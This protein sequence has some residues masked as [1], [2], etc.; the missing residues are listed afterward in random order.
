MIRPQ[1]RPASTASPLPQRAPLHQQ[2]RARALTPVQL[3]LQHHPPRRPAR[4]RLV[5]VQVRHQ[6][7]G[8]QQLLDPLPL[9]RRDRQQRHVPAVLLDLHPVLRQPR[10]HPLRI[11]VLE[12][13]LVQRD[14]HR[15]PRRAD[16]I[17]R[18]AGLRHHPVVG[19]DDQHRDVRRVG[20]PRPHP[21]E[22]LVPRRVD[23]RQQ[24]IA[25]RRL[26]RAHP[27]RD[28]ARLRL[29][30]VGRAD[31]VQQAG[32]AV[33][34]VPQHRHHRR[35]RPQP[36]RILL[37][38]E[39][40]QDLHRRLRRRRRR[41]RR[42]DR[43]LLGLETEIHRHDRRRVEV[44][45]LADVGHDP[46]RHQHLDDRDRRLIE[47]IREF[48]H[49]Q[50]ARDLHRARRRLGGGHAASSASSSASTAAGIGVR[51]ARSSRGPSTAAAMQPRLRQM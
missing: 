16:V 17:D 4:I 22:R 49:R 42:G 39:R 24:P 10:L 5:A 11:D 41:F 23:E 15:R 40:A 50:R 2:R 21:R 20:P 31:A 47:Q 7:Q 6:D 33:I 32:L 13:H 38:L 29:R 28:P 26:V 48:A 18:L 35:P 12:V 46:V 34:D 19:R 36:R 8:L 45:R 14:H 30:H 3:S 51:S 1:V 27:L 37:R 43:R 44:Q 25:D 9:G